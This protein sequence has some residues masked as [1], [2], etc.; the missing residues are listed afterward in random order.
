[1]HNPKVGR[2]TKWCDLQEMGRASRCDLRAKDPKV[3]DVYLGR[4]ARQ[5]KKL[6][7]RHASR[8]S[9]D[10]PELA[11]HVEDRVV[12]ALSYTISDLSLRFRERHSGL[13]RRSLAK[14]NGGRDARPVVS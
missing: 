9:G 6:E 4:G 12:P 5:S 14:A 7:C 2:V 1:M 10:E 8:L 13:F 3:A 11:K